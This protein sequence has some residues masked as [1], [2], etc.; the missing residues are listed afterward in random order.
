MKKLSLKDAKTRASKLIETI[1]EYRYRYHVLDDPK[2]NDEVY[3]SLTRELRAIEEQYPELHNPLSST[4]RVGGKALDK[5]VSVPHTT[6]MI[7]LNDVFS[8]D[9]V[10]AWLKRID[11][12][13]PEEFEH[14]FFCDIKMDGL[15]A[16]LVYEDGKLVRGLTRGDGQV[17]E[18][19]TSNLKTIN[20]IPLRLRKDESLDVSL[21]DGRLEVRGEVIIY[22]KDFEALNKTR[23]KSG[24][25]L[26]ANPRNTAAGSIRQ[27]D[28]KLAA[29]RPLR[30]HAYQLIHPSIKTYEEQY[31]V[32]KKLGFKVFEHA[33]AVRTDEAVMEFVKH[34]EKKR[35]D[36]PYNTDG[37]V[38]R[39]NDVKAYT[40]L[41]I[42][43]KNPR[44]A[45]AY[46]Y[47]A[48]QATSKIKDIFISIGRTGA[49]TPVAMLEPVLIAGSTVQMAT[50]HNKSELAKKDIRVGD[51]VVV[52]KAGDIIPEVVEPII[53][54]RP[55]SAKEFEFP[56]VCPD[57]GTVLVQ[58]KLKSV[59]KKD[60]GKL[61]AVIRC[62]NI[63]CP[64]RVQNQIQHFA[65]K[66]ALDIEG[67]GEKNVVALLEGGL[68][69]D[70][71]DLYTL[72]Q[73]EV[74]KLERFAELSSKNLVKAIADKKIP[75]LAR[76]LYGL[77]IR[78]VG[79]QTAIDLATHFGSMDKL[80]KQDIDD[81][82]EVDGVG[83]VV[84]ESVVAWFADPVNIE[85]LKKFESNEVI[86]KTA[87]KIQGKLAGKS[88][89]IT[90]SLESM[91]REE[92]ATKIRAHG[93]TFQSS[94]GKDTSYLVVADDKPSSKQAKAQKL[95]IP[96]INEA[97]LLKLLT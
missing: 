5:F 29:A 80:S 38:V 31:V 48:E 85:L 56:K 44:G 67:L 75:E 13:L 20:Q 64:A 8:H 46:K 68:I 93:G 34:W 66:T 78:H 57:C 21:Y 33:K 51:T 49:A 62:P 87:T 69:K 52:Q 92:A 81:L 6:R 74:E 28:P 88:F 63:S 22:N 84:A 42:V 50:L 30:F 7:S 82:A 24:E 60:E 18:D 35:E 41:G 40:N 58:S 27:L 1:E 95:G 15:A 32:A 12:L 43:G 61:E 59:A 76:F 79:V 77:G 39:M 37:V 73:T 71:A 16:A 9:D 26:Y 94:V 70:S 83:D 65:S 3:D 47:P 14:E 89:V 96:V 10:L 97:D 86:P 11:K 91:Q 17:G 2:V 45:V 4:E 36:L 90:G 54:L 19:V 23:E 55:K 72:K 53:N 25:S